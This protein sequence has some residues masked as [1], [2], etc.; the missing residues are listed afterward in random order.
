MTMPFQPLPVLSLAFTLLFLGSAEARCV[1]D[2]YGNTLCPAPDSRCVADRY[3]NWLC[4]S[5]GGDAALDRYGNPVCGAGRCV[6]DI[7]GEVWCSTQSRGSAALDRYAKAV[8]T[9]GCAPATPSACSP[10]KK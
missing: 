6:A 1:Q 2:R 9:G 4:S 10:L 5:E 8:C 7:H 3:G